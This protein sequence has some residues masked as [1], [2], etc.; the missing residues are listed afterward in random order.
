MNVSGC[1][2]RGDVDRCCGR[3]DLGQPETQSIGVGDH[4]VITAADQSSEGGR[5]EIADDFTRKK[6][7]LAEEDGIRCVGDTGGDEFGRFR[8]DSAVHAVDI[9]AACGGPDVAIARFQIKDVGE[10]EGCGI[11][12]AVGT[13]AGGKN[14][15]IDVNDASGANRIF[16]DSVKGNVRWTAVRAVNID[17]TRSD[18]ALDGECQRARQRRQEIHDWF[19][20][21]V[22]HV[23]LIDDEL[24]G[25]MI[26]DTDKLKGIAE[27]P[28]TAAAVNLASTGAGAEVYLA[29]VIINYVIHRNGGTN[30]RT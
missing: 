3:S 14:V 24:F 16:D 20:G 2:R 29:G 17:E 19:D 6:L 7:M 11:I 10:D 8:N 30:K 25:R 13:A 15:A 12:V 18:G 5:T 27:F 28:G 23:N 26:D 21:R 4:Y 1:A 22:D 9:D